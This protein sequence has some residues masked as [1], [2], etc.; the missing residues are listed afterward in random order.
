[1]SGA[2][3]GNPIAMGYIITTFPCYIERIG[4]ISKALIDTFFNTCILFE[5]LKSIII[6]MF[7]YV[8]T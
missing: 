1:M 8:D 6:Y 3:P 7:N 2:I 4:D 5:S